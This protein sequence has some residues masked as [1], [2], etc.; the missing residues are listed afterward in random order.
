[1][2][3]KERLLGYKLLILLFVMAVGL[4]IIP[5]RAFAAYNTEYTIDGITF[6]ATENGVLNISGRGVLDSAVWESY[7]VIE[8]GNYY[9]ARGYVTEINISGFD[10]IVSPQQEYI[11]GIFSEYWALEKVHFDDHMKVIGAAA[12]RGCRHL[13]QVNLGQITQIG[14]EAFMDCTP[15]S[16]VNLSMV[17]SIGSSAFARTSV[18]N[19]SY[20]NIKSIGERAFESCQGI[21]SFTAK[22]NIEIGDHAFFQCINLAN[23][24]FEGSCSLRKGSFLDCE[25]LSSISFAGNASIEG[26]SFSGCKLLTSLEF[27]KDA[28][29]CESMGIV[30]V[31]DGAN[32]KSITVHGDYY[33]EVYY[34]EGLISIIVDGN[35]TERSTCQIKSLK[36][37]KIKGNADIGDGAF[38][39]CKGITTLTIGGNAK[40]GNTAFSYCPKLSKLT[41]GGDVELDTSAFSEDGA[42]HSVKFPGKAVIGDYA[43]SQDVNN[44]PTRQ[45][46]FTA[47][48]K[49]KLI[50]PKEVTIGERAFTNNVN[51]TEVVFNGNAKLGK[52]AFYW[53]SVDG[54]TKGLKKVTFKKKGSFGEGAF[55]GNEVLESIQLPTNLAAIPYR[56]FFYCYKL[57][58][59][60]IPKT[61]K[62]I[63][64][65][66]FYSTSIS[67][68]HY[69]GTAKDWSKI[70]IAAFGN[71]G[72]LLRSV[73][74]TKD[75]ADVSKRMPCPVS[76]KSVKSTKK[77][78]LTLTWD[79]STEVDG[80]EIQVATDSKF[81]KNVKKETIAK[82]NATSVSLKKLKSGKKYYVQIRSYKK[83]QGVKYFSAWVK[84]RKKF[85]FNI[86]VKVK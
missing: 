11:S 55:H 31:L 75:V 24:T 8:E 69:K 83:I 73:I 54:Q 77:A 62:S 39:G 16:E 71:D 10:A 61:V 35:Y 58:S 49:G 32:V 67:K 37:I 26:G 86:P 9:S 13:S 6:M 57:K 51:L 78:T 30:G 52:E 12:F 28:R 81:T 7:N 56:S 17:E 64:E 42:L 66:A 27:M 4:L 68:V 21:T 60:T 2:R 76:L 85:D 40:I 22:Q 20:N 19:V 3:I 46:V 84:N 14:D 48:L 15:L 29:I 33:S 80:Y 47:G 44:D 50:F 74:E 82:K 59:I 23:V 65:D 70:E 45:K 25:N 34:P 38:H 36:E 43:F 63:E 5:Q 18:S 1:M 72:L 79:K 53:C 41:F